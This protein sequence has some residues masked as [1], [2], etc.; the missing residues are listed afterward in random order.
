MNPLKKF[1]RS[2]ELRIQLSDVQEPDTTTPQMGEFK[3]DPYEIAEI[4]DDTVK[5]AAITIGITIGALIVVSAIKEIV[6]AALTSD[7]ND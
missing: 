6:I 4:I 2:H 5:N 3:T 1:I 7:E